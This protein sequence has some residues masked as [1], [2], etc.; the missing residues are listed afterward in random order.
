MIN[1]VVLVGRLVADPELR[2]TTAGMSVASFRIAVD[3]S[4]RG[5]NG[6][7]QTVFLPITAWGNQADV[8][9]KFTRK[10]SL[11]GITGRITQRK[12]VNRQN[13]E[14]TATEI[15]AERVE[16]MD[17]KPKGDDAGYTPDAPAPV[18]PSNQTVE[19]KNLDS[20]DIV[21]DDLPF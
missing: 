10:G 15:S 18:G 9:A 4:R 21:D 19:S 16:L 11:I 5:P 13:V 1:N 2:K 6:E 3:D 7:K 20:I 17:P 14:V 12:Y 8:V